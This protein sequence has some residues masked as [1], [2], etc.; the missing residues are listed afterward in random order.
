MTVK[1]V[2]VRLATAAD[3]DR[4]FC[5]L[6]DAHSDNGAY[7][8]NRRKV[9][10]TLRRA[11]RRD[12]NGMWQGG[13]FGIIENDGEIEA[14]IGMFAET[15]WYSDEYFLN[16]YLNYVRPAYRKSSNAKDL[17]AFGKWCAENINLKLHI[18][19][20]TDKRLAA[21]ER[22]YSRVLP[23]KGCLFVYDPNERRA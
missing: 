21:K 6:M 8:I 23:K 16:E 22:L 2:N 5:I 12:K 4:L 14:V 18:G 1:P 13:I 10:D 17:L 20:L 7:Q 3:E 9:W 15:F 19:V 11:T